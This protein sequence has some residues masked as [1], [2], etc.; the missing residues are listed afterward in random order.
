MTQPPMVLVD[1]AT[2]PVTFLGKGASADAEL[3]AALQAQ[4][5]LVRTAAAGAPPPRVPSATPRPTS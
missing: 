3:A 5:Q 2:G 4:A 1:Y